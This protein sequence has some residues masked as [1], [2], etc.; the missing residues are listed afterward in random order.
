MASGWVIVVKRLLSIVPAILWR[1][2]VN[3]QWDDDDDDNDDDWNN[4]PHIDM[5]P[6]RIYYPDS[7]PSSICSFSL[8]LYVC[9]RSNKYQ[10]YC[11]WFDPTRARTY[12]LPLSRCTRQQLLYRCGSLIYWKLKVKGR[13]KDSIYKNSTQ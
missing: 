9:R 6:P 4:S 11:L 2:Q 8:M 3:F 7:E 13:A 10:Y 12:D 5:S 1:E